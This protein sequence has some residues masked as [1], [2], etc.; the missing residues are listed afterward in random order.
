MKY[1]KKYLS[2]SVKAKALTFQN[3]PMRRTISMIL[4]R[5]ILLSLEEYTHGRIAKQENTPIL[6]IEG[7]M[8]V[9][10]LSVAKRDQINCA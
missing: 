3:R 8:Y 9:V 6:M 10:A 1:I 4:K 7:N 5:S 2:H